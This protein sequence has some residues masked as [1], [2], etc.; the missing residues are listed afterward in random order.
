MRKSLVSV[1]VVTIFL[2][3]VGCGSSRTVQPSGSPA[4]PN[5][6]LLIGSW[7]VSD[8]DGEQ[9]GAVLRL[10]D[11]ELSLWRECGAL[12]GGY[13]ANEQGLFVANVFAGSMDCHE[14]GLRA[15]QWLEDASRY[16]VDGDSRVLLD[17]SGAVL[18]S[19]HP[20]GR[21][22]HGPH[23]VPERAEPPVVTQ[24]MISSYRPAARLPPGTTAG[25]AAQL[26]GRWA[27]SPDDGSGSFFE[28]LPDGT[29]TGYDGCNGTGGRWISGGGG[30]FLAVGGPSTLIG[31][32]GINVGR[33]LTDSHRTGFQRNEL[34]FFDRAGKPLG[35][36]TKP[37]D[38]AA[39]PSRFTS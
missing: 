8:A 23:M 37:R 6:R 3:L 34:V 31:C 19:L 2:A 9:R 30:A 5:P 35:R 38:V 28:L 18:A 13:K 33:W 21:P 39:Q 22:T 26:A 20:G 17:D 25:D 32:Q 10:A 4:S 12:D 14:A 1:I 11:G 16:R 36:A 29:W 27:P 24:E 7:L 15:P